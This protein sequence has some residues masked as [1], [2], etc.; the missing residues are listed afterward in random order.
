MEMTITNLCTCSRYDEEQG[1]FVPSND[2]DGSCWDMTVEDFERDTESLFGSDFT[3]NL[4][5]VEG[6]PTWNGSV[7]GF[8]EAHNAFLLLRAITPNSEWTLRYEVK[9]GQLDCVLSHH[10]A[11]TGGHMTVTPVTVPDE[12]EDSE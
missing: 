9:D 10:D 3:T 4:W 5:R 12:M 6:F 2:C 8:V 11:P 7:S 1:D